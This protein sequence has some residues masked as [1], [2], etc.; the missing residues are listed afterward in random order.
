MSSFLCRRAGRVILVVTLLVA[1]A[2]VALLSGACEHPAIGLNRLFLSWGEAAQQAAP[3]WSFL[4][5]CTGFGRRQCVSGPA[6]Q[7]PDAE[8]IEQCCGGWFQYP[9]IEVCPGEEARMGCDF[10]FW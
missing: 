2:A 5:R 4:G 1:G 8:I 6:S 7:K 9:W 3:C 10:C